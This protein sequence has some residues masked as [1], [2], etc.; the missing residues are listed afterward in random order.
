M[1]RKYG[2]TI[3]SMVGAEVVTADGRI[4]HASANENPELFWAI[5][6]GGGNFGV[7]TYFEF[8]AHPLSGQVYAG[9]ISYP[10]E[11][12][13]QVLTGWRDAM[14]Q[15][16][17]ELT[18][19][20]TIMPGFGDFPP[21]AMVM[22]CYAGDDEA[23][24]M[25][26][27]EPLKQLGPVTWQNVE[28]KDYADVLEEAHPP[29]GVKAMVSNLMAPS[30]SDEL[31]QAIVATRDMPGMRVIQIRILGGAVKRV[32]P[33]ATAFA[34]RNSEIMMFA[35]TF[36]P[37]TASDNELKEAMKAWDTLAAFGVG[38]YANFL[39]MPNEKDIA[40]TYPAATYERLAKIKRAYDPQNLFNQNYNIKPAN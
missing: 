20:L 7:V 24:A 32:A 39:G 26:A 31:I 34:Y 35:G 9:I 8:V 11:N 25:Q 22:V 17:E 30:L 29:E 6:G 18:S 14:R 16:P 36:V 28:K 19:F 5:R 37:F 33:D 21:A 3:D 23:A 38:A 27:L 12:L 13:A 2:L 15:A 10:L 1:V 4:L 40:A